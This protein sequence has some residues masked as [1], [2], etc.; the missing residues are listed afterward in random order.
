MHGLG[1]VCQE[2]LLS[3]LLETLH[4]RL[5]LGHSPLLLLPDCSPDLVE[6]RRVIGDLVVAT[7]DAARSDV[8][9]CIK[10]LV[11]PAPKPVVVDAG[12]RFEVGGSIVDHGRIVD[13]GYCWGSG[14]TRT[15]ACAWV[16]SVG[17]IMQAMIPASVVVVCRHRIEAEGRVEI[18]KARRRGRKKGRAG[19]G[20]KRA[21]KEATTPG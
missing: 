3:D 19:D 6:T 7:L 15:S 14:G 21:G 11:S 5:L 18:G 20:D 13:T 1:L 4:L 10:P 17:F 9:Q 16:C 2:E 8:G 12:G